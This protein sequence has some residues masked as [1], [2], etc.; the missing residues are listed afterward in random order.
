[1]VSIAVAGGAFRLGSLSASGLAAGVIAG[2]LSIAAGWS[3]GILLLS[4]F[5]TAT[6]LSRYRETMKEIRIA[7]VVQKGGRRDAWQVA[8]NGG[9]FVGCAAGFLILP[10]DW[11]MLLAI[12]ALATSA[13]DTWAT[14]VGTL[15]RRPPRSILG[16]AAVPA[17]T[18]GA[19]SP[20]GTMAGV[21]GALFIG[22]M[23][24]LAG[25][26]AALPGAFV[27][28]VSG[29]SIDSLLGATV[30]CRRWC[31]S[32]DSGTERVV[33]SCGA[34]TRHAGG[35]TWLDN[36]AVNGVSTVSGGLI[37]ALAGIWLA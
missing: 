36:D 23:A 10:A 37:G 3:W 13:A 9:F 24:L 29:M 22:L 20:A 32:C 28:G 21:A 17:G 7:P 11:W 4:L 2:T 30:Q 31:D 1:M 16:G 33:H 34:A 6:A 15:S 8:A 12:G 19:V 26:D 27:G 25:W 14:E 35:V 18:S 5:L